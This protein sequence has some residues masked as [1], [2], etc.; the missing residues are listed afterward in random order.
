MTRFY[1]LSQSNWTLMLWLGHRCGMSATAL[2]VIRVA[3]VRSLRKAKES[4]GDPPKRRPFSSDWRGSRLLSLG[5]CW[6]NSE[7][8]LQLCLNRRREKGS[9][10]NWL[11]TLVRK[12][13]CYEELTTIL[14][15]ERQQLVYRNR[16]SYILLYV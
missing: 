1:L 15:L 6:L 5:P 8:T 3:L 16:Y 11:G 13:L 9:F 10:P 4:R 2:R 7:R 12:C 14:T